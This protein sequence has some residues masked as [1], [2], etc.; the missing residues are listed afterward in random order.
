LRRK[1]PSAKPSNWI[2][3]SARLRE[4]LGAVYLRNHNAKKA[5]D[6]LSEA[7]ALDPANPVA[8]KFLIGAYVETGAW[9]KAATLFDEIGGISAASGD[10]IVLLWYARTLVETSQV[11]R[12]ER[13]LPPD[14]TGL[15]SA[16]FFS[17]GT[18]LAQKA[19]Y[20][21]AVRYLERIP[22]TDADDAVYFNEGLAYS[23]LQEFEK[24]RERY[25]RAIDKH[26][27][28]VDAYFRTG[29]DYS[30]AGDQRKA[31]PWLLRA[32]QWAHDRADI[33]YAFVEQLVELNYLDT[34]NQIL[35]ESQQSSKGDLLLTT[36]EGDLKQAKHDV[37]GAEAAY[38]SV[39]ARQSTFVPA[40]VGLA[41]LKVSTSNNQEARLN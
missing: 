32:H 17:V 7:V 1:R 31:L 23:H 21:S 25:F 18:L 14:R 29:L 36:G 10:P 2:R 26:P 37:G 3:K 11:D 16:F 30:A 4:Q 34:A 5:A 13:D 24:A 27:R 33:S 8:K 35:S 19:R 41:R 39:L 6:I 28:H 9:Q 38:R 40:L 15:S 20:R 12:L 22:E